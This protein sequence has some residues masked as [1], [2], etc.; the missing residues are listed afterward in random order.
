MSNEEI[1]REIFI[2]RET[3]RTH[4]R[5]AMGKLGAE[6]RTEAVPFALRRSL[7]A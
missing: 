5:K 2:S 6:R 4:L 3:V 7:I 1:G